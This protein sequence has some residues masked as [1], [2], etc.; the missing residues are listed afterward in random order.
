MIISRILLFFGLLLPLGAQAI[1]RAKVLAD[2]GLTGVRID[3]SV[4]VHADIDTLWSTLTDY[5]N[6]SRFVPS[7]V[8]SRVLPSAPGQPITVEQKADSG[9]FSFIMPD[10]VVLA[11]EETPPH[12]IRF[13]ALSGSVLT[14]TGEWQIYGDR[15]PLKL[16]YRSRLVPLVPAPPMVSDSFIEKEVRARFEAV[17]REA[18][19][20]MALANRAR[21][22]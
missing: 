20:R 11:M 9:I 4:N 19:R 13:R 1:E 14:M 3:A 17:A 18:E 5:N 10:H 15:A 12:R 2:V 21:W 7:M 16:V 8:V 22:R 6:L